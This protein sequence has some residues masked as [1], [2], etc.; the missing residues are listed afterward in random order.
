M[1]GQSQP[2]INPL[3]SLEEAFRATDRLIRNKSK[4]FFFSTALL[5]AAE[6]RA[7]RSLYAFC[8]A[9]DDLVDAEKASLDDVEI[10]RKKVS[11]PSVMQT[12]PLLQTWAIIRQEYDVNSRYENELIDGVAMDVQ[13]RR[14]ETWADLE[15]YCYLVASTV[16]LLS[17][18]IIGLAKGITFEQA[19]PYAIQLGIALQLTNILRDVGEDRERGRVYLPQEDLARFRLTH[20]DILS[21]VYDERFISLMRYEIRRARAIYLQALPGIALLAPSARA[22]VGASALLYRAILDE[23]EAIQYRV[24]IERAYTRGWRKVA[25]LPG[26]L[27][28]VSQLEKPH[29]TEI[30]TYSHS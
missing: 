25:M 7:I 29:I 11:L 22:A 15:R 27:L 14:Y 19:A 8:R 28:Q 9:T 13:P 26:I 10:W 30:N 23:I 2:E 21:G 6:R 16:G 20:E 12:D 18:P 17:I 4:T 1:L 24:H 3:P 5:P